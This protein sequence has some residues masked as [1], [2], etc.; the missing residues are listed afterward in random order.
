MKKTLMRS[1]VFGAALVA[2]LFS[3]AS[4]TAAPPRNGQIVFASNRATAGRDLYL[5]NRDGSGEHRLTFTGLFARAPVWSPSGER[6]AFSLRG[7]D[8]NWGGQG[9]GW[10]MDS[11]PD[12]AELQIEGSWRTKAL[13]RCIDF[14]ARSYRR[15]PLVRQ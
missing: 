8:G 14:M 3:S 1:L 4:A 2:V 13:S 11:H 5:V 9:R 10:R 7:A 12:R 6:I 15:A